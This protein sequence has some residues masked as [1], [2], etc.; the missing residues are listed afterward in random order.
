M[1]C[2][3][4]VPPSVP[5][6]LPTG[7]CPPCPAQVEPLPGSPCLAG[8][9]RQKLVITL[10]V[11]NATTKAVASHMS[12]EC[13]SGHAQPLDVRGD[14]LSIDSTRYPLGLCCQFMLIVWLFCYVITHSLILFRMWFLDFLVVFYIGFCGEVSHTRPRN[15][16][17]A[18]RKPEPVFL[19]ISKEVTR[20]HTSGG[21]YRIILDLFSPRGSSINEG[22]S[23]DDFSVKYSSFDDAVPLIR[24]SGTST[25]MAKIDIRHA[26]RLCPVRRDQWGL[27]GYCLAGLVLC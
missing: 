2:S 1:L 9:G 3:P 27:L 25:F 20:G 17:S 13:V 8:L 14:R 21:T 16:L 11:E 24:S 6:Q 4:F 22:I 23:R 7:L 10:I 5:Q 15:L 18:S 26:S 12:A 19:A